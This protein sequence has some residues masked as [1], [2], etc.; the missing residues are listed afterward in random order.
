LRDQ[1]HSTK[2]DHQIKIVKTK[3]IEVKI[4][5][6][7]KIGALTAV[8]VVFLILGFNFLKGRTLFRTGNFIYAKYSDTKKL[9][10]SN[11]VYLNGY[12]IGSV[13][14]IK[15]ADSNVSTLVVTIK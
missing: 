4:S 1:L 11:P 15:A 13:Y 6:E 2:T 5:N 12:P 3:L 10:S 7:T 8:A 9:M 14:D